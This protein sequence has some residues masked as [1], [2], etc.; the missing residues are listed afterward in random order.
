MRGQRLVAVVRLEPVVNGSARPCIHHDLACGLRAVAAHRIGFLAVHI[1][2]DMVGLPVKAVGMI[3]LGSIEAEIIHILVLAD[4]VS[5]VVELHLRGVLAED[6]DIDLVPRVLLSVNHIGRTGVGEERRHNAVIL[7][8]LHRALII[9]VVIEI[10]GAELTAGILR[11]PVTVAVAR[12]LLVDLQL[13]CAVHDLCILLVPPAVK[14]LAVRPALGC[15]EI[16]G[17][18][19][20]IGNHCCVLIHRGSVILDAARRILRT[21]R[22]LTRILLLLR[23]QNAVLQCGKIPCVDLSVTVDV[24]V[25]LQ[26]VGHARQERTERQRV[27]SV[28]LAVVVQVTLCR[29]TDCT[30][31]HPCRNQKCGGRRDCTILLPHDYSP[32]FQNPPW[33]SIVSIA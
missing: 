25:F 20:E 4:A 17:T 12:P 15:E 11:I 21:A 30:H 6:L 7:D 33:I 29:C 3:A 1:P 28:Q 24:H 22:I 26:V 13:Q 14:R 8:R 2:C 9:A 31:Q 10:V 18:L 23:I 16:A 27:V 32:P 5:V 19:A